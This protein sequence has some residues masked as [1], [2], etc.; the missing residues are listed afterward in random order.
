MLLAVVQL[1]ETEES[2]DGG[3]YEEVLD[4]NYLWIGE[5]KTVKIANEEYISEI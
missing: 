4:P 5:D 2:I 3:M 1:K